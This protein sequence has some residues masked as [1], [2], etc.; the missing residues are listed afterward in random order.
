MILPGDP[1]KKQIDFMQDINMLTW[2]SAIVKKKLDGKVQKSDVLYVK[3]NKLTKEL[4]DRHAP[5]AKLL[6]KLETSL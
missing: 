1:R 4:D 2:Q 6:D 5:G 3:R